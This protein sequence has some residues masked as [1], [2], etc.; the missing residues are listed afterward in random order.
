[1]PLKV[2]D[3][4]SSPGSPSSGSTPTATWSSPRTR[5]TPRRP[6]ATPAGTAPSTTTTASAVLRSGF[7]RDGHPWPWW[8][9]CRV[10][11]RQRRRAGLHSQDTAMS[12]GRTV[13]M[14]ANKTTAWAY[15]A[16]A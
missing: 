10:S 16:L 2:T 3:P 5:S 14:D 8:G 12:G 6:A 7:F 11:Q 1:V 4:M 13:A 15:D 9:S